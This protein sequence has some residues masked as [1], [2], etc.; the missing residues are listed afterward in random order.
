[1]ASKADKISLMRE[2]PRLGAG[3]V[4]R[5][6][7]LLLVALVLLAIVLGWMHRGDI[8]IYPEQ[9]RKSVV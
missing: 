7:S 4:E 6:V 9:D 5:G 3:M 8:P 2:G 1:M